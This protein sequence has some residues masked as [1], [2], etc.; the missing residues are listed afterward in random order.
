MWRCWKGSVEG[1][2]LNV[3]MGSTEHNIQCGKLENLQTKATWK[4]ALSQECQLANKISGDLI[5][6]D[7]HAALHDCH[8]FHIDL[9][10][11]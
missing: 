10:H 4:S 11:N 5:M 3:A 6:I 2:G 8:N 7:T 9:Y 1:I